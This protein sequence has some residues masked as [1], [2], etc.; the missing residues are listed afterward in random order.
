MY[1]RLAEE[2]S[3]PEAKALFRYLEEYEIIHQQLLEAQRTI[4]TAANENKKIKTPNWSKLIQSKSNPIGQE[5][6]GQLPLDMAAAKGII[7]VLKEANDEL[8]QR[9]N[10]HELDFG[11]FELV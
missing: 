1:A 3:D 7:K 10:M 5:N 11:T 6:H 2:T 8:S 9:Q 4:L